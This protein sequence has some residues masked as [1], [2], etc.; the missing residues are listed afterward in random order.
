MDV[1]YKILRTKY[2]IIITTIVTLVWILL[3]FIIRDD[4]VKPIV[5]KASIALTVGM[6]IATI[7][8]TNIPMKQ[9][10]PINNLLLLVIVFLIS[11][12]SLVSSLFIGNKLNAYVDA[13][14]K[15]DPIY[16]DIPKAISAAELNK[17]LRIV[18]F[19]YIEQI[20]QVDAGYETYSFIRGAISSLNSGTE[21][22][23]DNYINQKVD[24]LQNHDKS[25]F[26]GEILKKA[27]VGIS[28]LGM[29]ALATN[30]LTSTILT[31][32]GLIWL[33]EDILLIKKFQK[34]GVRGIRCGICI[35]Q[36]NDKK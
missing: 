6:L 21:S 28:F 14:I 19:M 33:I 16:T 3:Y 35:N 8:K 26:I 34:K 17:E 29:K 31:I 2:D 9:Y 12:L 27:D 36:A 5:L 23:Y 11:I 18:P 7:V 10:I 22:E 30:M 13:R 15:E 24:Q 4:F 25:F 20:S 32:I 1:K